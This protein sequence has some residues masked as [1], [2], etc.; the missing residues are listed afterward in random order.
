MEIFNRLKELLESKNRRKLIENAA[1]IIII[2]VIIIIVGSTFFSG[3]EKPAANDSNTPG[4]DSIET[5]AA[6]TKTSDDM[7]TKLKYILSQVEGAGKVEVMITY[8]TGKENIPAYDTKTSENSTDEKD[9]GGGARKI[10]QSSSDS[11]IVFKS[12][13]NGEKIPVI[14]KEIEPVVKGVLVVAEGASNPQVREKLNRA[15]QVL[16]DIPVHKIQV[17]ER[18]K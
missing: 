8:S 3:K 17:I 16:L 2:G 4:S 5:S 10:S 12:G 7:E 15:V 9:S 11:A 18:K 13:V 6:V 14:I 1:I